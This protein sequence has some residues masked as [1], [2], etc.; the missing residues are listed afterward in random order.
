MLFDA[1]DT[2]LGELESSVL[3]PVTNVPYGQMRPWSVAKCLF[4]WNRYFGSASYSFRRDVVYACT[5][6]QGINIPFDQMPT[7]TLLRKPH[8]SV[9]SPSSKCVFGATN[10]RFILGRIWFILQGWCT[11]LLIWP[12]QCVMIF[13]TSA[14]YCRSRRI[15]TICL[16][17]FICEVAVMILILITSF[18]HISAFQEK[19]S[20]LYICTP[21]H[22]PKAIYLFWI[23]AI[24]FDIILLSLALAAGFKYFSNLNTNSMW[25]I[26]LKDNLVYFSVTLTAYIINAV[27]W[28]S[29]P[30]SWLEI[31]QAFSLM[32]TSVVGIRLVFNLR[33]AYYD[34]W[35]QSA[36]ASIAATQ[37]FDARANS[38]SA[39]WEV[40]GRREPGPHVKRSSIFFSRVAEY[41]EVEVPSGQSSEA[42][43]YEL[44][45]LGNVSPGTS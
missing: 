18:S 22:L 2:N 13:R 17:S 34:V 11:G 41:S 5:F 19:D 12:M 24:A 25:K 4:L 21:Y 44:Q 23:P 31:P 3:Y 29:L 36:D 33:A 42:E 9:S 32:V 27:V 39:Q 7:N 26:L 40:R 16:A 6:H 20:G 38:V 1:D 28:M 45:E 37:T 30:A 14:M 35:S 10:L 8:S 15:M 43:V